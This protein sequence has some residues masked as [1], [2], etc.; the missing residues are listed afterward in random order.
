MGKR[1][2]VFFECNTREEAIKAFEEIIER[3]EMGYDCGN[4]TESGVDGDWGMIDENSNL[5]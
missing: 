4:F 3:L 1:F 5:W 2:E